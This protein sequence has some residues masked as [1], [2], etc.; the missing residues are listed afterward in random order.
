M[1]KRDVKVWLGWLE[2]LAHNEVD[3]IGTPIGL[4]PKYEDLKKL[5]SEIGKDYPRE[6]YDKQF[7]FYID[8]IIDRID[9]QKDAYQKEK[10]VPAR[11]FHIYK[12]QKNELEALKEK[13]G[14]V[15]SVDQV[16]SSD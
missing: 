8:N 9:L 5:F 10:G 2:R 12:Q 11:V 3:T 16:I 6:L 14:P 15:V 13:Y 4:I 1:E 7:S